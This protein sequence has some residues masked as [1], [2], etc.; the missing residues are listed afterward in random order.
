MPADRIGVRQTMLPR[1]GVFPP[2]VRLRGI[3]A[4]P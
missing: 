3:P 1:I 4:E 2:T